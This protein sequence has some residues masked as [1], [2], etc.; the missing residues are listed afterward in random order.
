M[1]HG[2]IFASF[3]TLFSE[4]CVIPSQGAGVQIT[5]NVVNDKTPIWEL[6]RA[7][8]SPSSVKFVLKR[9]VWCENI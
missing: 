9:I 7:D 8:I 4:K 2:K 1:T 3:H 6:F 5:I